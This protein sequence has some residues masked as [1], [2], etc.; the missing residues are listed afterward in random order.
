MRSSKNSQHI[1]NAKGNGLICPMLEGLGPTTHDLDIQH[2]V[3]L[4]LLLTPGTICF[5]PNAVSGLN[6]INKLF[7]IRAS[8]FNDCT[9]NLKLQQKCLA[10]AAGFVKGH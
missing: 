6:I 9:D 10:F 3:I 7:M 8:H 1:N 4:G 5:H 2:F